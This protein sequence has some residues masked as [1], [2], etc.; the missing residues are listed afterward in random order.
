MQSIVTRE[1]EGKNA[2]LINKM[3]QYKETKILI[4][5][6]G[7]TYPSNIY[8]DERI[9]IG[10]SDSEIGNPNVQNWFQNVV[11]KDRFL[12]LRTHLT[13]RDLNTEQLEKIVKSQ[14]DSTVAHCFCK[15]CVTTFSL[16]NIK[17]NKNWNK[18]H[19]KMQFA[20]LLVLN[21]YYPAVPPSL[22]NQSNMAL[23]VST[24][25]LRVHRG[26][27]TSINALTAFLNMWQIP[28][29]FTSWA[30]VCMLLSPGEESLVHL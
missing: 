2:T 24:A 12:F 21:D 16:L 15:C 13:H 18:W 27:C 3:L 23:V 8:S 17:T 26:P 20:V 14:G 30:S 9:E 7:K 10:G 28:L 4:D 25:A 22:P 29:K 1:G 6:F 11:P 19:P 5:G